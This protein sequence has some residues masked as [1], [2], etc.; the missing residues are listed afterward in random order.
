M[1]ASGIE[2]TAP[3][4][5][6][7]HACADALEAALP[8]P[9]TPSPSPSPLQASVDEELAEEARNPETRRSARSRANTR[10]RKR[11]SRLSLSRMS[12]PAS[13]RNVENFRRAARISQAIAEFLRIISWRR[14]GGDKALNKES[15]D[16]PFPVMLLG[17]QCP[18]PTSAL[19]RALLL[20]KGVSQRLTLSSHQA[21]LR[22]FAREC[23]SRNNS[24][25]AS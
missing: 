1:R 24:N 9:T 10:R 13:A 6:G 5:I 25:A 17:G 21:T 12:A 22:E 18:K 23:M 2:V 8:N 16:W 20:T 4:A 19:A 3:P 7:P 14:R 11:A 15:A